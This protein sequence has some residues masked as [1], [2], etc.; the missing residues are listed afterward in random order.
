MKHRTSNPAAGDISQTGRIIIAGIEVIGTGRYGSP[1][2]GGAVADQV[3]L[4]VSIISPD[5]ERPT[6]DNQEKSQTCYSNLQ[7]HIA[8]IPLLFIFFTCGN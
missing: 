8:I 3:V 4:I 6:T 7:I 1:H 5:G 2:P